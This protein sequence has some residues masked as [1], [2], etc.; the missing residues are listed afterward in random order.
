MLTRGLAAKGH[1][2]AVDV[3][4]SVSRVMPDVV[5]PEHLEDAARVRRLM[6]VHAEAAEMINIG[7]YRGGSNPAVDHSIEMMPVVDRF[8]RQAR[9]D[10]PCFAE[11]REALRELA[12]GIDDNL[13]GGGVG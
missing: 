13:L 8:L 10:S 5:D 12:S 1:Y 11:T 3:L 7:A 9:N 4:S 6:A 2:P